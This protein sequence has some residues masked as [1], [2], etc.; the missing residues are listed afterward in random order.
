MWKH[1][2]LGKR[3]KNNVFEDD[4]IVLIIEEWHNIILVNLDI[5]LIAECILIYVFMN[6]FL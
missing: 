1:S 3:R 5:V 6:C 2:S 4:Q